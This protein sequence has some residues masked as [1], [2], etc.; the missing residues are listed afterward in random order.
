M[1]GR[2]AAEWVARMVLQS[3]VDWAGQMVALKENWLAAQ[4]AAQTVGRRVG[5]RVGRTAV[6]MAARKA[7][8]MVA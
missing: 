7:F 8:R 6:K 4:M 2:M 5:R 1:V 3:V